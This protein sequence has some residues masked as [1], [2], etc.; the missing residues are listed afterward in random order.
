MA[1]ERILFI[2]A[3]GP[4]RTTKVALGVARKVADGWRFMPLTTSRSPSRKSHATWEKAL[5]RW[6]GGLDRTESIAMR[7]GEAIAD[8]IKRFPAV[9]EF[10]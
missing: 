8:A 9:P 3:R 7:P 6:T 2:Q 5:P 10:A 1:A 4:Q